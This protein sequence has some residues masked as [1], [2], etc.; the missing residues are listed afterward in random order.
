MAITREANAN[1]AADKGGAFSI[2]LAS[3]PLEDDLLVACFTGDDQTDSVQQ[4]TCAL[5]N[6]TQATR[7]TFGTDAWSEI[8]Y[9]EVSSTLSTTTTANLVT[10]GSTSLMSLVL[11]R[12]DGTIAFE[13]ADVGQKGTGTTITGA[14][15]GTAPNLNVM[16]A[17]VEGARTLSNPQSGW[18]IDDQNSTGGFAVGVVSRKDGSASD[19]GTVDI[20]ASDDWAGLHTTFT[21]SG[22]GGQ[23]VLCLR[24]QGY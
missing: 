10:G 1:D 16:A 15:P 9:L 23:E 21:D 18:D 14:N 22:A 19:A 12:G 3:T 8:W 11:Y 7:L 4:V 5:D 2:T 17:S 20:S 13:A 24:I 6:Y